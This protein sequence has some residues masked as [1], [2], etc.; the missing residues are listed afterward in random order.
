MSVSL[1]S[2]FA[3]PALMWWHMQL[4]GA[5]DAVL[6]NIE[7]EES[8]VRHAVELQGSAVRKLR[9]QLRDIER[10]ELT[11]R[12]E[13]KLLLQ[14]RNRARTALLA[15]K[16]QAARVAK[17]LANAKAMAKQFGSQHHARLL[18]AGRARYVPAKDTE[19]IEHAK[20]NSN[21]GSLSEQRTVDAQGNPTGVD[22]TSLKIQTEAEVQARAKAIITD[23]L[24]A[25]KHTMIPEGAKLVWK[26]GQKSGDALQ[27]LKLAGGRTVYLTTFQTHATLGP[28]FCY[29]VASAMLYGLRPYALWWSK[30]YAGMITKI[31]AFVDFFAD[32][33]FGPNDVVMFTD[34]RDTLIRRP[35]DEI[36]R[37]FDATGEEMLWGA[38]GGCIPGFCDYNRRGKYPPAHFKNF[39]KYRYLNSGTFI[40][41]AGFLTDYFK[42]LGPLADDA[43]TDIDQGIISIAFIDALVKNGKFPHRAAIDTAADFFVSAWFVPLEI[44]QKANAAIIHFNGGFN[45]GAEDDKKE[46]SHNDGMMM[47]VSQSFF[48]PTYR[49]LSKVRD[50]L[51]SL[52]GV[53]D[54]PK[55]SDLCPADCMP[56]P[57]T[58][59][60][61]MLHAKCKPGPKHQDVKQVLANQK[62][63]S[64]LEK[65]WRSWLPAD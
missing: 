61:D 40:G 33:K 2:L 53:K 57:T 52:Q 35:V 14:S 62:S 23:N 28:G 12:N 19:H 22:Q 26:R 25:P 5:Q 32:F 64:N 6:R 20:E 24:K 21:Q 37:R 54:A 59:D 3:M 60:T 9:G 7:T 16:Q 63:K 18:E 38:D 58:M 49:S 27:G 42:A 44:I 41:K 65:K 8:T 47:R 55:F 29:M 17:Q 13:K 39:P 34:G 36:L 48:Y 10:L 43:G 15:Q 31:Y 45:V 1:M 30:Q 11:R 46:D 4:Y 56:P 50:G 51:V